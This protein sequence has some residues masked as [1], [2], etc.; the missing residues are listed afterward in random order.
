MR[1]HNQ[2]SELPEKACTKMRSGTP[3][4]TRL[5]AWITLLA[6]VVIGLAL[7]NLHRSGVGVVVIPIRIGDTPAMVYRPATRA[8][9]PVVVIAHGFAGSQRLMTSFALAVARN[10]YI[11]VTFDFPGHGLHP[12]P[13]TGSITDVNGAT[14]VLVSETAKVAAF[15]RRLGNGQLA[16][17][18]HSMASDIVVRFA[19]ATPD[20]SATIA[21][22]MFSPAVTADSPRNLLIIDGEWEG[23]LKKEALR[24][25]GLASAP[26]EP[27]P[28]VT[29]GA[30]A[31]GGARRAAFSA[32]VEHVS[33]L[34]SRDSM[35]EALAWLDQAFGTVRTQAPRLDSRG[36]WILLL[37]PGIVLLA[38]PLSQLLPR[39][40]NPPLGADLRWNRLPICLLVPMIA[41]PLLLRVLPTHFLPVLVA[42][43]LVAHFALYGLLTVACLTWTQRKASGASWRPAS[44][45]AFSGALIAV[46]AFGFVGL[47]WPLDRFVTEFIPG[48]SRVLLILATLVGN[49][50]FYLS[51]E[52]LTRGPTR[53]W[54]AYF[55]SKMAFL[56]S[57]GIG[58]ALDFERLL[59][60]V[61]IMPIIL[62]FFLVYGL[63]SEWIYRRTGHPFVAG[64][65]NAIAMAWAIGV[66]FPLLAS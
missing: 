43:Y 3:S 65:A 56:I 16:V 7:W 66:T 55:V 54:G 33:V 51:D 40:A 25:V 1:R 42:D 30:F 53:A 10:G 50:L 38:R 31:H 47:V 14:Q 44:A 63:F 58:V 22:S 9:G 49:L 62:V 60:L 48:P 36:P 52:W 29:Y 26:L 32:H 15:A 64:I 46:V 35:R 11:A 59:F 45:A 34:F 24:A 23:T 18:G 37:F 20:L 2:D 13:L 19:Q 4:S 5:L 12:K 27:Q 28:G 8:V 39:L 17:L 6:A 41:T 61:I 21:V 57:L